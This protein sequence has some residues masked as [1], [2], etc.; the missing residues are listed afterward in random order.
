MGASIQSTEDF[1]TEL[2]CR[3]DDAMA[4]VPKHPQAS[5]WPGEVVTLG[6]LF[7]L[8]GVGERAF[9]RWARRDLARL[10]PRLPERT[11]LFPRLPERT[12]LFPRLPE[13][14]R[15]FR[16]FAA[17]RGWA[18]RFLAGPTFF[19]VADSYGIELVQTRRLG[20]SPRQIA[21][22][23]RSGGR[24]IA[25][26]KFGCVINSRG[27]FCAPDADT[28]NVYDANAFSPLV[29]AYDGR[30]IV[31]ADCNFHKSPFHRK[32]DPDPP[33]LKVCRRG[34]WEERRLVKTVFSMLDTVCS[35]K[36]LTERAWPY[37]RG[38]LAFVAAAFNLLINW[39]GRPQLSLA[40]FSL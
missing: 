2:F 28:A 8:K 11:R 18:D 15:L 7:A 22:R 10:F 16:L 29:E 37:L 31:L 32:G 23:G 3:V 20:R 26:A 6:L 35:L 27:E 17:R 40:R 4:G 14:T 36:Q 33:N 12:R 30:M 34:R 25:G 9:H 1:V 21:G 24:W 13:R 38:H 39:D 5:L 19:G